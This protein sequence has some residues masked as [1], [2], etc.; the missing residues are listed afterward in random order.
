MI[1][2]FLQ[3]GLG[4]QFFQ[5]YTALAYAMQNKLRLVIP[6]FKWDAEKRPPYW[7]S[8]FKRL[9]DGLDPKLKPG[10]L[11]R[12]CEEGFH[13]TPLPARTDDVILFG[14]FQS[15]KYFDACADAIHKKLNLR[16]EQEMVRTQYLTLKQSIS[17]HFRI[18]DYS[19]VQM[20]YVLLKDDYYINALKEIIKRT[21]KNDWDIIYFC[22]E[23]DNVPVRQRLYK[24]KKHFP[25]LT[26]HKAS[27]ELEDWE[28][29]LLMS[30][31]DHN[32]IA[33]STFSWWGAYLNQH[34]DKIVCCPQKWFGVANSDKDTKDLCPPQWLRIE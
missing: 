10:N 30:L 14:Y 25:K 29:L 11:P 6:T 17:L 33:N 13:Y 1:S 26:F 20:H 8:V 5:L 34:P 16:L 3:A 28:Q 12:L 15:Y 24:I 19:S 31:S 9:K 27:D 4:N 2:V 18:G 7:D 22:E 23:K 32:I 21:K